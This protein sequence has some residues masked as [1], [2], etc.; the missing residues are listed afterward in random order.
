MCHDFWIGFTPS[1]I[2][3]P[4]IRLHTDALEYSQGPPIGKIAPNHVHTHISFK[5]TFL[6]NQPT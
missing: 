6:F 3:C 4:K 1:E 5:F 2:K